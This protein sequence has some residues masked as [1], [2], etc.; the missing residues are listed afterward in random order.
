M[1]HID[2]IYE[3]G[4]GRLNEDA[5]LVARDLYGV[6]DGATSLSGATYDGL[7]G[8]YLAS[9]LAADVFSTDD[10]SLRA[11][12]AKANEA[13]ASRM[14]ACHVDLSRKEELWSTSAAVIRCR[15]NSLEWCQAG[16]CRIQ[17]IMTDGTSRQLVE[18]PDHDAE[19]LRLWQQ[20]APQSDE[21]IHVALADKI[22]EVRRRMNVDYGV[23]NG[24]AAAID[25]VRSGIESLSGVAAVILYT[26]GLYVPDS[27]TGE[28]HAPDHLSHLFAKGGLRAVRNH[29]RILQENDPHCLLYPRFKPSDD[30]SAI[31]VYQ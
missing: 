2:T 28:S 1:P 10:G 23:L 8:G 13:I 16:D 24:E 18:P 19:T 21:P 29:I 26:D 17:L 20:I 22:L 25:F 3:K 12:A 31:A 7:T 27:T 15:G 11:L 14:A 30:I 4:T 5:Q 9:S 6:F